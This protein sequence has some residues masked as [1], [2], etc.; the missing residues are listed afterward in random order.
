VAN[1]RLLLGSSGV[2]QH[3]EACC[4]APDP[5]SEFPVFEIPTLENDGQ[6]GHLS[7]KWLVAPQ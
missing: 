4:L 3:P 5:V 6:K 1:W 2:S 7:G